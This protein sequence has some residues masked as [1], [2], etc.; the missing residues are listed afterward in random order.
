MTI[1]SLR[2]SRRKL[3]GYWA[4][5]AIQLAAVAFDLKTIRLMSK[6]ALMPSL[7]SWVHDQQG[8]SLLVTATLASAVGDLLME[9]DQL[10]P[11]MAA[12]ALAHACYLTMF[13]RGTRR[14]SWIMAAAYCLL[15]LAML[16]AFWPGLGRYRTPVAAYSAMLMATAVTSSWYGGRAQVGGALLLAS[17]ALIC[18]KLADRDFPLRTLLLEAAYSIGQ[19]QIAGSLTRPRARFQPG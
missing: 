14:R 5:A 11:A 19:H 12:F 18:A 13:S 3:Y 9:S 10:V 2:R 17:D 16:A 15:G 4:V 1:T 6:M 7:A 8:P